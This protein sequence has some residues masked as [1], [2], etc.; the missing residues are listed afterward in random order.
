[1]EISIEWWV[2]IIIAAMV[3]WRSGGDRD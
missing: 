2:L 1:M 3:L